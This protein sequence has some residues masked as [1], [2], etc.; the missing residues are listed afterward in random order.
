MSIFKFTSSFFKLKKTSNRSMQK[1]KIIPKIS[2]SKKKKKIQ[3]YDRFKM[4]PLDPDISKFQIEL[5]PT[6]FFLLSNLLVRK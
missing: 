1:I 3:N 5:L 6:N 4:I 2:L